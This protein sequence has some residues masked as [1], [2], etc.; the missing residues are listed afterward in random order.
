MSIDT[1]TEVSVYDFKYFL[2]VKVNDNFLLM[3]A[4]REDGKKVKMA[5]VQ[6]PDGCDVQIGEVVTTSKDDLQKRLEEG[7]T[8]IVGRQEGLKLLGLVN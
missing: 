6:A 7:T 3:G 5:L 4:L 1:K 2:S 8:E